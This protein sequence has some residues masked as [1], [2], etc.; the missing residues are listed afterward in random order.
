MLV[1]SPTE[2]FAVNLGWAGLIYTG[3]EVIIGSIK[4]RQHHQLRALAY[5]FNNAARAVSS[6]IGRN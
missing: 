1:V 2:Q 6:A 3:I 4:T 5:R